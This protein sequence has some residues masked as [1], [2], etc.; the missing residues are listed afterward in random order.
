MIYDVILV[1]VIGGIGLSGGKGG[2]RNVIVGTLLI[3][4]LL[5]GMTILDMSFT[6]QKI[7]KSLILLIAIVVDSVVNPRDEQIGPARRYL[8][9]RRSTSLNQHRPEGKHERTKTASLNQQEGNMNVLRRC[10]EPWLSAAATL[11]FADSALAAEYDDG[12][13]ISYY[14]KLKGKKVAFV[15]ISMG[16]DL[17]QGWYRRHEATSGRRSGMRSSCAIPIGTSTPAHRR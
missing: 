7:I 16:F 2:I 15:P 10:M 3:G 6:E 13:S 4:T 1:V 17:T 11:L 14:Q 9:S 8:K 5:N 12:L